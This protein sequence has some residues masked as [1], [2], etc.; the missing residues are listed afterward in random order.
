METSVRVQEAILD[1]HGVGSQSG[2][3]GILLPHVQ[4]QNCLDNQDQGQNG[5]D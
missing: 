4:R 5:F 1:W 3:T 2:G